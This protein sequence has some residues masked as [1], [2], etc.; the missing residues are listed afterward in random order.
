MVCWFCISIQITKL[1][2]E[3][4]VTD[5]INKYTQIYDVLHA[6]CDGSVFKV[7]ESNELQLSKGY[8]CYGFR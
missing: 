6:S 3:I 5:K 1:G 4:F 7:I 2:K 8:G